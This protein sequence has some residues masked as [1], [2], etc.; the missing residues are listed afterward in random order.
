MPK[1]AIE[2]VGVLWR[3]VPRL[4]RLTVGCV[5]ILVT[6][7]PPSTAQARPLRVI[8]A[9]HLVGG[10]AT[11][12][13]GGISFITSTPRGISCDFCTTPFAQDASGVNCTG[14][15]HDFETDTVF[16]TAR[17]LS[18]NWQF[19]G[20]SGA[21]RGTG[22]TALVL[23]PF[24]RPPPPARGPPTVVR[25]RARGQV[26]SV[27]SL[28]AMC[29]ANY[30]PKFGLQLSQNILQ[31]SFVNEP[32]TN[33]FA[34]DW[35]AAACHHARFLE[36]DPPRTEWAAAL[37]GSGKEG[38]VDDSTVAATGFAVSAKL[39]DADMPFTH[40]FG[41]DWEFYVAPDPPF[42]PLLA[43]SNYLNFPAIDHEYAAAAQ[44]AGRLATEYLHGTIASPPTRGAQLPLD[45]PGQRFTGTLG[46]ETDQRLIAPPYRVLD[47]DRVAV[48]GRWIGDCGHTDYHSE[49]HPPLLLVA[50]RGGAGGDATT[51]TIISRPWLVSQFFSGE[52]LRSHLIDEVV[53]VICP[54]FPV[55][56][57]FGQCSTLVEAHPKLLPPFSKVQSMSYIVT[58]PTPRR[59]PRDQLIAR[60]HFTTR[61]GVRVYLDPLL[62]GPRGN[63]TL[64]DGVVVSL[65]M[66]PGRYVAA[67]PPARHDVDLSLD[68]INALNPDAA[69]YFKDAIYGSAFAGLFQ[70]LPVPGAPV[71]ITSN[72][73][74]A[75]LLARGVRTDRYDWPNPLS[76]VDVNTRTVAVASIPTLLP[77][78][79]ESQAQAFPVY[80]W[81]E[82]R[83]QRYGGQEIPDTSRPRV[84]APA[85]ITVAATRP[86]GATWRHSNAIAK[87]LLGSSATDDRDP[88]PVRL[89]PKLNGSDVL[90][91]TVF[92]TGRSTVTFSARDAAGNVGT[93]DA[94]V[95]VV[96]ARPHIDLA[97]VG[98]G[99]LPGSSL[100][101]FIDV[102]FRNSGPGYARE[103]EVTRVAIAPD[104]SPLGLRLLPAGSFPRRLGALQASEST[105]ALRVVLTPAD[106]RSLSFVITFRGV[107]TLADGARR[108]FRIVR[109]GTI[110]RGVAVLAS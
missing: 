11:Y 24:A 87:F 78:S 76:R 42:L 19:V 103:V 99:R 89:W 22:A 38:E 96:T 94:H 54:G 61:H 81:L 28:V 58:P 31:T 8:A 4:A 64:G 12:R 30:A 93:A 62:L 9:T 36:D 40:P 60:Y 108:S 1:L 109:K 3:T 88:A 41:N 95:T 50:A 37:P 74:A 14:C 80:G 29:V 5:A 51:T 72:P 91:D 68:D 57:L 105:H 110:E 92:P 10:G 98:F 84:K 83:W 56:A 23:S 66:S 73:V 77:A 17:T 25:R 44:E 18:P 39:S 52:G 59:D 2:H 48:F 85:D 86:D 101:G 27:Q 33:G 34:P 75:A 13:V 43:P 100:R 20:W 32:A 45:Q 15:S 107:V 63:T 97:V 16:L 67:V 71:P 106:A 102:S 49:I 79:D 21:C 104:R 6:V 65:L 35:V 82:L 55:A 70:P 46:V 26:A 69:S 47:G 90:P 53:K 7:S